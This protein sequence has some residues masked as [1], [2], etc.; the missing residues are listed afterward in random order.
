MTMVRTCRSLAVLVAAVVLGSCSG[1]PTEFRIVA[2]S[3]AQSLEPIVQEFCQKQNAKCTMSYLGSLDIALAVKDQGK[4][5]ADA[6]WPAASLWIDIYDTG[7]QVKHLRS[8]TQMPV[9]LGVRR[10]KAEALG[11]V[12]KPVSSGDILAAVKAGKLKFLMT[13]ATQSNSGAAAYLA[14]LSASLGKSEPLTLAD[15]ERDAVR[16]PAKSLLTGVERSAGSSGWLADLFVRSEQEDIRFDAMWNYEV[17]IGETNEKLAAAG[18]EPLYAIYPSDGIWMSDAPLGFIERKRGDKVETLF[19][20]LQAHLQSPSVQTR[21]A[22]TGRRMIQGAR[23]PL[24]ANA[25]TNL[26]PNRPLNVFRPPEPAVIQRALALYQEALRRP[27]LTALCLDVSGSMRGAGEQQLL[28]AMRFLLTPATTRNFLVQWSP[29]DEIIL[30]PF[31]STVRWSE[32]ATGTDE[33]QAR[34]LQ[35]ALVLSASGGT[36]FYTC[37]TR[38]LAE[39]A[40]TLAKEAHL[41]AIVVMTDGKSGGSIEAFRSQWTTSGRRVPV[42]GVT[43]GSGVERGQLDALAKLTGGRVFDGT[44]SLADAFRTLRGYN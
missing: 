6:V 20:D 2:G 19:R 9:I 7:R 10:S 31:D 40:P 43:F 24:K 12:G 32:R 3:E 28:D 21:I 14:M 26:D 18:R 1:P 5:D 27:S 38:A 13:S 29:E 39:M 36:D 44:K 23:S 35:R 41:P 17:T 42:F 22:E 15:L 33:H 11:W 37:A 4:L 8:I 25:R 34:L 16:E 30:L